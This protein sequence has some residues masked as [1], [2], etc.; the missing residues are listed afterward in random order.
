[1]F[2]LFL[3]V[4]IDLV[5]F[6]IVIPLLPF[7]G[8]HFQASPDVVTLLL[9]TYSI[10]Q[11]ISAPILGRLSDRYGRRPV[12][13]LS[14]LGSIITYVWLGFAESL[15]MLFIARAFNGLMAGNIATAFAYI[16][17]I[18]TPENRAKG[19]GVIGAAFGLGFIM[20]PAIGG[21]LA[22]DDPANANFQLPALCA[23][24]L[25][26]I[27][28]IV[29]VVKLKESLSDE[30]R[31][32]I[33]AQGPRKHWKSF[34]ETL[35]RPHLGLLIILSFVCTFVFAGMET[36]FAMWTRREFNWGP[37]QNGYLF[38]FLGVV[39]AMIQGGLIGRLSR[40]FGEGKLVVAGT[41]FLGLGLGLIPLSENTIML[42]GATMILAIGFA[43]S[44]PS[45]NSLI[46]LEADETERGGVMGAS[47]S[48]ATLARVLGPILAGVLFAQLG[49]DAPY[50]AGMVIMLGVTVVAFVKL[51]SKRAPKAVEATD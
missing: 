46:S 34:F 22:G 10:T 15:M 3:V 12:L 23:A 24:V 11:L 49:R 9:A 20:G 7:F 40:K 2:V 17:D 29:A 43:L 26:A 19:M 6:G 27:A 5:G 38:A 14:L 1:M 25:S 16:A 37:E 42:A 28:F 51:S 44:T 45:L 4:F 18:T 31:A 30:V 21:I 48:A 41:L 50:F 47:R 33:A 35:T 39:S 32:K 36:T 8:E 13:L